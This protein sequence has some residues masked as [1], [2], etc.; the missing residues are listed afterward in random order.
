MPVTHA[1]PLVQGHPFRQWRTW[2]LPGTDLTLTGYSRANDKTFFCVPELRLGLDAGLV[3]G[4]QPETVLLTH[5]H[6]DHVKDLDFLAVRPGG[7]DL[8]VPA[9]ALEHVRSYLRAATEVNQVAAYDETLAAGARVHG[10]RPGDE[11]T[12]GRRGSHAAQV[13]ECRH[14]VPCVGY[15]VSERRRE[16]LPDLA[17]QRDALP[18]AEFGRLMA[19]RR[20]AG[21]PVDREANRPLF[22]YLGDT[23]ASALAEAGWLP[24][25]PVVITECTFLDD[26][27]LDRAARIGHTVWSQLRPVI[28][29]NPA[30]LFVLIHFSLRH[31]D[32]EIVDFFTR[33]LAQ[34]GPPNIVLWAG[35][36]GLLPQQHGI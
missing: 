4:R 24:G 22:A 26:A 33:E 30:T 6:L 29:A 23:H 1:A 16:L 12:F 17:A 8:Y 34:G 5:T 32:T 14:K 7:V 20:A 13:V 27:E 10:V 11:F 36:D 21:E 9:D 2:T 15:V 19:A 18:K 25:T 31:P 28:E 3:E 35:P